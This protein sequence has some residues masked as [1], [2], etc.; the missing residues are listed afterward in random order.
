MNRRD[1]VIGF[2]ILA[3][4]A[5]F[6]YWRQRTTEEEELQI[7]QTLSVEDKIE[8]RFNLE[9]PEDVDKAELR[10][11][12]G[13]DASGIATRKFESGRFIYT[14]LADLPDPEKGK[15]YQGWLLKGDEAL[16]STGRMSVAKGGWILEFESSTDYMNYNKVVVTEEEISDITPERHI[17]EGEF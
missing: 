13:G 8:E 3:I 2:V 10:D 1:I 12:A 6:I 15:F 7:P 16:V 9:I 14:V 5:G 11:I 17:L 4:L